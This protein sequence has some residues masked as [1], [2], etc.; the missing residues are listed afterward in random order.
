MGSRLGKGIDCWDKELLKGL[1]QSN[2]M[3]APNNE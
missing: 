2:N 1:L 3:N